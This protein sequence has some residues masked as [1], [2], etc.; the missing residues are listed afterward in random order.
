MD[1]LSA[2]QKQMAKYGVGIAVG[3]AA[4]LW[5]H[6]GLKNYQVRL[7]FILRKLFIFI[8][9]KMLKCYRNVNI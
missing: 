5:M 2:C 3:A 8:S 6:T 4:S 7:A 9:A 1:N